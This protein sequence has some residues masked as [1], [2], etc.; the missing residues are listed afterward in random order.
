RSGLR[1]L[2][3]LLA[4]ALA[5]A[6]CDKLGKSPVRLPGAPG[7]PPPAIDKAKLESAIDSRFGGVG[8]C[9]VVADTR[10][11]DEVYRYNNNTACG[12][13]QPRCA[14]FD[15]PNSLIALEAGIVTP[16]SK[17]KWDKSPQPVKT[18]EADADLK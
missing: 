16:T 9:V 17:L 1:S 12:R 10:T 13:L 4:L 6:A 3:G 11:G 2:S 18:W 8:T 5:L 15:V 14:T 7:G